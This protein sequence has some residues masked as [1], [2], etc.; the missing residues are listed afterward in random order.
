M[1]K[2]LIAHNSRNGNSKQLADEFAKSYKDIFE[3]DIKRIED[4]DQQDL[5]PELH[6]LILATRVEAFGTDRLMRSFLERI[7][8]YR[9]SPIPKIGVFFTH[10]MKWKKLFKK[11]LDKTIKKLN[12]FTNMYHE[13]LEVRLY[14]MRG[15]IREGQE[16]K[17]N[18]F[19]QNLKEYIEN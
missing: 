9:E 4:I 1:K 3:V 10:S 12:N 11:G 7:D 13:F 6:A 19:I 14:G 17:I 8:S 15:P 16:E 2:I 5:N 18:N